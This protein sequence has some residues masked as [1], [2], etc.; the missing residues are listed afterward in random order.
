MSIR[1]HNVCF[2]MSL[3]GSLSTN[4]KT[5]EPCKGIIFLPTCFILVTFSVPMRLEQL[6]VCGNLLKWLESYLKDRQQ[7]VVINGKMSDPKSINASVPQGSILGPLLFL[8]YVNDLVDDLQTTPYLFT[9]DTSLL[10][11][12]NPKTLSPPSLILTMI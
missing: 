6:G 12:I 2:I 10:A 8:V 5:H 3:S 1:K 7:K 11:T 9:D 4:R